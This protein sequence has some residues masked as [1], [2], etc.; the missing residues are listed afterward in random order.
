MQMTLGDPVARAHRSSEDVD[1]SLRV[2][3]SD[4]Y[5]WELA[6]TD[7]NRSGTPDSTDRSLVIGSVRAWERAGMLSG[8]R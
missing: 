3:V 4:L 8:R 5:A 7:V 1:G 6:P 2:D